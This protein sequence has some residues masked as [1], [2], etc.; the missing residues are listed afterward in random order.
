MERARNDMDEERQ[1]M[2]D[3]IADR[4]HI[5]ENML[6]S[7]KCSS[8]NI[9]TLNRFMLGLALMF[10]AEMDYQDAKDLSGKSLSA[11]MSAMSRN[12]SAR[13]IKKSMFR[14]SSLLDA[15]PGLADKIRRM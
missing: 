14:F 12:S 15:I 10:D 6:R 8:M 4:L 11:I 9:K 5:Y 2:V 13:P 3:M 1:I 7:G